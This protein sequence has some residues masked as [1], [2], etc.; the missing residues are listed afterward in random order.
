MPVLC[1]LGVSFL[2]VQSAVGNDEPPRYRETAL[3]AARWIR[4]TALETDRGKAWPADPADQKSVSSGLYS[5]VAGTVLFF[6]EAYRSTQDEAH[7]K[8][9]RAGAEY[10]LRSLEEEKQN[11][12][13]VGL[14]GIGFALQETSKLTRD[15]RHREGA[16]R[17]VE[18]L[19]KR[20]RHAGKGVE[21]NDVT[22]IIGG[23]A[24]IGLFL[25]YAAREI[26]D[27]AAVELAVQAGERLLELAQPAN[28]GLK[29]RMSVRSERLMPN[30]SHGTAGVAYF[31]A[32]LYQATKRQPFLDAALAGANYLQAI[33]EKE[34]DGCLVFHHEPGGE[35]L[36]Y[37]GWCHG[38]VG[39]ARL[40]Y[41]LHQATG[42]RQWLEWVERCGRAVV[43]SGI[44]EKRTPGFWENASQCCGSAGVAGFCLELH[45]VTGDR[46]YI[47]FARHMTED[48]LRRATRDDKGVRWRSAEFRVKPEMLNTQTGYMQGAAGIGM[49]L[50]HLDGFDRGRNDRIVLPDSPF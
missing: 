13:Y 42:E 11:G 41:R 10:L 5:G 26:Q 45:R 17:V 39:S 34:G 38:P 25:L 36:F 7:L 33:A 14:A 46:Q 48:L 29:W 27:K 16:K 20:A 32:T 30:F 18:L 44:P 21:W 47:A 49:M 31:L 2:Y 12:L 24:G 6:L 43:R 1:L 35:K 37:L 3:E 8:E 19:K 9:A 4:S 22:D 28:G 50:L 40:F 15:D 23:S